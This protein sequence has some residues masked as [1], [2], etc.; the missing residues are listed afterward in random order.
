M[1]ASRAQSLNRPRSR[2]GTRLRPGRGRVPEQW[3]WSARP[4][5]KRA[6]PGR[7]QVSVLVRD[8]ESTW[9]DE[10]VL[11]RMNPCRWRS[12]DGISEFGVW[13]RD[14]ARMAG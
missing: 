14:G 4:E 9:G 2:G 3:R 8:R 5:Q 12:G 11:A 13:A 6:W 7:I 10:E 1:D